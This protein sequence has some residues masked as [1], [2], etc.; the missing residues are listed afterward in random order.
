MLF[1]SFSRPNFALDSPET[2]TNIFFALGSG[3]GPHILLVKN[4]LNT[5]PKAPRRFLTCWLPTEHLLLTF[6]IISRPPN[7]Y[8]EEE[9]VPSLCRH[10]IAYHSVTGYW[11]GRHAEQTFWA[12]GRDNKFLYHSKFAGIPHLL[13]SL[14]VHKFNLHIVGKFPSKFLTRIHSFSMQPEHYYYVQA[15]V[16]ESS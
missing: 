6:I 3:V 11:F 5:A 4:Q 13:L 9:E 2:T 8:C 7:M 15:K 12:V 14:Y 16:Q 10:T 1:E